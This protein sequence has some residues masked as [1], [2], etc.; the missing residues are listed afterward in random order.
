MA[1]RAEELTTKIFPI[2]FACPEDT[3]G[4]CL[5]RS[6]KPCPENTRVP[7]PENTRV[8]CPENTRRPCPEDSR[9]PCQGP[10][11]P[12]TPCPEDTVPTHQR[13]SAGR[14]GEALSLLQ[15]QLRER[16]ERGMQV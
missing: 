5:H 7:C 16:L 1:F 10:T 8:P 13:E 6:R 9:R 12:G 2:G 4:K 3:V 11:R 14:R 15:Q